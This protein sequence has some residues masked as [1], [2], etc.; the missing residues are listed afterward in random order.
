M[1][2]ATRGHIFSNLPADFG[3]ENGDDLIVVAE[4]LGS[5]SPLQHSPA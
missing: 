4:S 1:F 2:V 3:F 5:L